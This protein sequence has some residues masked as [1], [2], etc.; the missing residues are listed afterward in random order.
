[1]RPI[2]HS[3][4]QRNPLALIV[5]RRLLPLLL[6]LVGLALPLW[7]PQRAAADVPPLTMPLE[8]MGPDGTTVRI[9][10]MADSTTLPILSLRVHGLEDEQEA[11]I[12]INNGAWIPLDNA[13][14]TIVG[15]GI[16]GK[17]GGIG[18]SPITLFD[19]KVPFNR[20]WLR[21]GENTITFRFNHSNG[22]NSGYRVLG[23]HFENGP[24]PQYVWDD[25]AKW[26][27]PL[28]DP[29]DIAEGKA[30]WQSA[31]LVLN[32]LPNAPTI[33]AHC[34][35]CHATD[36][37]DLKY[38]NYSNTSIIVRSMFHGLS[39]QQ[40]EQIASYIRSLPASYGS[41]YARP[42]N[43]PYQPGPGLDSHGAQEWAAGAGIDA[44][45]PNDA[46]MLPYL[47]PP[48][49]GSVP[50]LADMLKVTNVHGYLNM[51]ELPIDMPLLDWNHWLPTMSPVDYTINFYAPAN[52]TSP[53]VTSWS[54]RYFRILNNLQ[55]NFNRYLSKPLGGTR[56]DGAPLMTSD[57]KTDQD[58][59]TTGKLTWLPQ[60]ASD[61][62]TDQQKAEVIYSLAQWRMVRAWEIQQR[63]GLDTMGKAIFT[64]IGSSS[65]DRIEPLTW[66]N[67]FAFDTSSKA[68]HIED[69]AL[70]DANGNK[71]LS[72]PTP[73]GGSWAGN[74]YLNDAWYWMQLIL[75]PGNGKG[76]G[77][78]PVDWGYIPAVIA[79]TGRVT[80]ESQWLRVVA[81]IIK[82]SQERD[83]G[84]GYVMNTRWDS[85]DPG[86][87]PWRVDSIFFVMYLQNWGKTTLSQALQSQIVDAMIQSWLA[88][89]EEYTVSQ[90]FTPWQTPQAQHWD[91]SMNPNAL[92]VWYSNT[93]EGQV[94]TW[95]SGAK[96]AGVSDHT[97]IRVVKWL[98][99]MWPRVDW[100]VVAFQ[101]EKLG[102]D[103]SHVPLIP[104]EA[105]SQ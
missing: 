64:N 56:P 45:L 59:W 40:G 72:Q 93:F 5:F 16:S 9:K 82:G 89:N 10:L 102:H 66:S 11:S 91:P 36:G 23:V 95:L 51:R 24:V 20:D 79:G 78:V 61:V 47:F 17:F 33:K 38:F 15:P 21:I 100:A 25:P 18:G 75:N 26:K 92:P 1:M 90:W 105:A 76:Y 12:Q 99:T 70:R 60:L 88:K 71:L 62:T 49:K 32:D 97:L 87:N 2:R 96:K 3:H 8:V 103:H 4:I 27:P 6:L 84:I 13:H 41:K 67:A 35:D 39:Y 104:E 73:L 34:G 101:P 30:L 86:W 68:L 98:Q 80:G 14:C 43:P 28:D 94:Y 77:N 37:R 53:F 69:G 58:A 7:V 52:T 57:F 22:I 46:A 81:L 65:N 19:L 42:W 44:V 85:N 48:S 55:N 63:F 29:K 54:G 50:T 31:T 74:Q 83:N